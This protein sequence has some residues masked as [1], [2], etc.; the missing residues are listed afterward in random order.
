MAE[1]K[2]A[3]DDVTNENLVSRIKAKLVDFGEDPAKYEFR[4]APGLLTIKCPDETVE[5]FTGKTAIEIYDKVM[6]R[7]YD[8]TIIVLRK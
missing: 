6:D 3:A 1:S 5:S 4:F 2:Y 7:C 8:V